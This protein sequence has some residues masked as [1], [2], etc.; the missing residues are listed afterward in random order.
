MEFISQSGVDDNFKY[1]TTWKDKD[2]NIVVTE[3]NLLDW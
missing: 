3:H 2:G 1:T